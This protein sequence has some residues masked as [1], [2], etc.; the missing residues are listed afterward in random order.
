M[1]FNRPKFKF[2][3]TLAAIVFAYAIAGA[4][5]GV[6]GGITVAAQD[7]SPLGRIAFLFMFAFL[8]AIRTIL[9]VGVPYVDGSASTSLYPAI[10]PLGLALLAMTS[11]AIRIKADQGRYLFWAMIVV[12][13][14]M[15]L[16]LALGVYYFQRCGPYGCV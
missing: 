15:L 4:V 14:I 1:L 13:G 6:M 12:A 16:G 5:F 3:P 7:Y 9:S 8:G 2:W 10:V 11:G